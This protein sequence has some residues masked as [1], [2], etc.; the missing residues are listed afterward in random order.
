MLN[1]DLAAGVLCTASASIT[2]TVSFSLRRSSSATIS[3]WNSG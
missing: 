1:L 3:P 2:R